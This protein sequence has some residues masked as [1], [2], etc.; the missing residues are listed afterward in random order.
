MRFKGVDKIEKD[1]TRIIKMEIAKKAVR[2]HGIL[3]SQKTKQNMYLEYHGHW[4]GKIFILP[5]GKTYRSTISHFSDGGK[6]AT[7]SPS[8][9]YFPYLEFGTRFMSKRPALKPAFDFVSEEFKNWINE[10]V[11]RA[12]S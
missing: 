4:E 7:V 11:K 5:T 6:T 10:Q 8:T 3:L 2:K 12:L 1:L 9:K